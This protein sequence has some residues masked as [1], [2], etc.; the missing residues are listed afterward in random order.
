MHFI[1]THVYVFSSYILHNS[2]SDS[3][4]QPTESPVTSFRPRTLASLA[5][6]RPHSFLSDTTGDFPTSDL[7]STTGRHRDVI[8]TS[9]SS[10][11]TD[12]N[13]NDNDMD[14]CGESD[15]DWSY[16]NVKVTDDDNDVEGDCKEM[17]TVEE[18]QDISETEARLKEAPGEDGRTDEKTTMLGL[19]EHCKETGISYITV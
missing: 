15:T 3:N 8:R 18:G 5:Q 19:I 7:E 4:Q 11:G 6:L 2:L 13:D 1:Y 12:G 16:C 17:E 10:L 9:Q 14:W